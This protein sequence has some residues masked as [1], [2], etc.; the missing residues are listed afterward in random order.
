[1]AKGYEG[2]PALDA[3]PGDRSRDD[4]D[5]MKGGSDEQIRD[6][7]EDDE[8]FDDTEDIDDEEEEEDG[9]V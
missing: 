5:L 9:G 4:E 8:D 2:I 7:G 3:A 1:M 6:V